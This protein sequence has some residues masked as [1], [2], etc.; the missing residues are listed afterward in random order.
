MKKQV[1]YSLAFLSAF[2]LQARQLDP[3]EALTRALGNTPVPS[4]ATGTSH[5]YTDTD[6]A[7]GLNGVYVFNRGFD[8]GYIV[9]SADDNAPAL[10]GYS[11]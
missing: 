9:V 1:L 4:R 8:N 10:L 11:D 6:S 2:G 5:V 3:T 7:T